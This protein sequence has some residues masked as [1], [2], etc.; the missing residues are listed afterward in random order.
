L[1]FIEDLRSTVRERLGALLE[2]VSR[3][4]ILDFPD[5][6]NIGDS[7]IFAGEMHYLRSR[8]DITVVAIDSFAT[9]TGRCDLEGHAHFIHGG[10]NVGGLYP[11]HDRNRER[12]A[13]LLGPEAVLIQAP[14][15]VWFVDEAASS[16]Y[17]NSFDGRSGFR[18]GVRDRES[19]ERL[20]DPRA[21]LCPDSFHLY[22]DYDPPEPTTDVIILAR[23]D[24]ESASSA[25]GVATFDWPAARLTDRLLQNIR[26]RTIGWPAVQD[27]L[28]PSEERWV[29][30][31]DSR[32]RR[33]LELVSR[34]SI[35]VTDRLHGMLLAL[36]AGRRVVAVDNS[37]R[38]LSSYAAA[39]LDG[40]DAPVKLAPN[41]A[42]G[43]RL[44][45]SWTG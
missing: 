17:H 16:A 36:H 33:G 43:M 44:A 10:G 18:I 28:R 14:Q 23:E 32:V 13:G 38:K 8:P 24:I 3:V 29:E 22:P 7:A 26:E 39:W 37:N 42:A 19:A 1:A 5:H 35:V 4:H 40:T 31:A 45:E 11:K 27:A 2:G 21:L 6:Q 20:R 9:F 15:S 25:P 41:L 12:I 34:G 30:Q